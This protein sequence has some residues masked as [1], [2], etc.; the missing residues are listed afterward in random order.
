MFATETKGGVRWAPLV[1]GGAVGAGAPG[2]SPEAF[3]A[4][5]VAMADGRDECAVSSLH[6][7]EPLAGTATAHVHT[8]VCIEHTGPWGLKVPRDAEGLSDALR[9]ALV[10]I[11][12]RAGKGVRLQWIRR[13]G[14]ATRPGARRVLLASPDRREA[15]VVAATVDEDGGM[16]GR[17]EW[18][19]DALDAVWRDARA[20]AG[21]WGVVRHPVWMVCA[22]GARDACCARRGVGF[23][24]ALQA[25]LDRSMDAPP[26]EIWQTSHLGGHRFAAVGLCASDG[27]MYGRLVKDDAEEL[28]AATRRGELFDLGRLRGRTGSGGAVQ[29]AEV[30]AR[31]DRGIVTPAAPACIEARSSSDGH[32]VTLG[33]GEQRARVFL[34]QRETA[35]D[36][37]KSCRDEEP[38]PAHPFELVRVDWDG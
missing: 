35:L 37:L 8:W 13:P 27:H 22:H 19:R 32:A 4:T 18:S 16:L 17:Q 14:G 25:A 5:L 1:V 34:R 29:A 33:F 24:L 15:P 20:G 38:R 10:P 9:E 21:P 23:Y 36:V 26:V 30:F 2:R 7:G 31:A 28:L 6:V 12:A 3:W 11:V